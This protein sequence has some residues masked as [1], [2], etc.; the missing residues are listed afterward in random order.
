[1]SNLLPHLWIEN[2][3]RFYFFSTTRATTDFGDTLILIPFC[4]EAR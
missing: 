1:M 2:R 4:A 3:A